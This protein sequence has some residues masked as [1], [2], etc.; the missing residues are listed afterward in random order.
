MF[1]AIFVEL[2][3]N[4]T[5]YRLSKETGIKEAS[6]SRWKNSSELPSIENLVKIA[7]YFNVSTDYLLGR[8]DN[9]KVN[10]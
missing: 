1:K 8:T 9:P 10:K 4:T 7:D 2:L 6:I 3:Q 5:A